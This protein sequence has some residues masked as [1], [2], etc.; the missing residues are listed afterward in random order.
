MKKV[1]YLLAAWSGPRDA[2]S[3][4]E[5]YLKKHIEYLNEFKHNLAQ[6]TIAHPLNPQ[7]LPEYTE[8]INSLTH[9]ECGT[10]IVVLEQP[11]IGRSYGHYSRSYEKFRKEFDYYIFMED[12]YLPYRHHFDKILVDLYEEE[13]K[14]NCGFLC[15]CYTD[16]Y[17]YGFHGFIAPHAAISNGISSSD[18]LETIFRKRGM[19]PHDTM[20]NYWEG[21]VIFSQ[22][23]EEAGY[24][25]KDYLKYYRCLYNYHDS[26]RLKMFTF[27][28]RR[29]EDLIVPIQYTEQDDWEYLVA[30]HDDTQP[31]R[32]KTSRYS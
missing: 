1:N 4:P 25:I 31:V 32:P 18:V 21:Q 10:P 6:V 12:D 28:G 30:Y 8:Y 22:A 29:T 7:E 16:G 14:N 23:F 26:N 2:W 9:L 13:R 27:N 5:G 17:S 19:L 3:P 24:T 11:N 15:G 20:R